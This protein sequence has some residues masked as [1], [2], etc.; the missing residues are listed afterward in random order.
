MLNGGR[1]TPVE[2]A[3]NVGCAKIEGLSTLSERSLSSYKLAIIL[4][5][6]LYYN[7]NQSLSRAKARNHLVPQQFNGPFQ[8]WPQRRAKA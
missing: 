8:V 6:D 7:N 1:S 4:F 3:I 2:V 5:T